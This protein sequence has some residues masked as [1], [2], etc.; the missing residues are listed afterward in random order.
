MAQTKVLFALTS[1]DA[2]SHLLMDA[3]QHSVWLVRWVRPQ[4]YHIVRTTHLDSINATHDNAVCP[5][6]AETDLRQA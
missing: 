2:I 3:L 6:S 5:D 4:N 1:G